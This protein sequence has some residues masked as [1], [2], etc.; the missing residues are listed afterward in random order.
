MAIEILA[1]RANILGPD[2]A[3]ENRLSACQRALGLGFGLEIDLRRSATGEFYIGHDA[4]PVTPHHALESYQD[5][6]RAHSGLTIAVNVK[7]SGYEAALIELQ[8]A[9][10]FGGRR[11]FYFDFELVEPEAPFAALQRLLALPG[12]RATRIA[13]RR[14]DRGETQPRC[15]AIDCAV[16]WVDEFDSFWLTAQ[17][18]RALREAGRR[19][20]VISPELHG[21][22]T[23]QRRQRWAQF[24]KWEVDGLCTD[25]ALEAAEFFA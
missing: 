24:K 12:G 7:E 3:A 17:D 23:S 4:A 9:G 20:Y 2:P 22:E 13:T 18:I 5:L 16:A 15:L 1:H 25:Y 6:F 8:R 21:F 19:I 10:A 14:S 11:D